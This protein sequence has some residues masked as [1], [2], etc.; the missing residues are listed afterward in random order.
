MSHLYI[1]VLIQ[2]FITP[3]ASFENSWGFSENLKVYNMSLVKHTVEAPWREMSSLYAQE[4]IEN[5]EVTT[6]FSYELQLTLS[7]WDAFMDQQKIFN[8]CISYINEYLN[9]MLYLILEHIS[10]PFSWFLQISMRL[11]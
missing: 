8:T 2:I 10:E 7:V 6:L 9:F 11:F 5:I 4:K 1:K 3:A